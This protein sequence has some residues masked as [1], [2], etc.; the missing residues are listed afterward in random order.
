MK[1]KRRYHQKVN[2]ED[3]SKIQLIII[4][5]QPSKK[6]IKVTKKIKKIDKV[7]DGIDKLTVLTEIRSMLKKLEVS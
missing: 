1:Q 4:N 2:Q 6:Q 5:S 7:L 3:D